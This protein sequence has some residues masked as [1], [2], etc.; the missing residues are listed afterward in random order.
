M[1]DEPITITLLKEKL[2]KNKPKEAPSRT[3]VKKKT[4]TFFP[5]FKEPYVEKKK[6]FD[7]VIKDKPWVKTGWFIDGFI[8]G[9]VCIGN[10][11]IL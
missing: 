6:P 5:D 8:K 11:L 9:L 2:E 1:R 7:G 4:K 3:I 10:Y